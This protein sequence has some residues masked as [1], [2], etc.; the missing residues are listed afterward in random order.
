[1]RRWLA[2]HRD[3]GLQLFALY[4]LL[5]VPFL[6]TLWAFDGLIGVRIRRDVQASNLALAQSISQEV[7]LA[8]AKALN[9]VA[10]LSTYEGVIKADE[11]A[12]GEIFNLV[13][14]TS[15]EVNLVYRLGPN[16]IMLYHAPT[17]PGSTVGVDFSFRD[18][19]QA[20]L[21]TD[22][23][24]VSLGRIS[25]TTNQAVATAVM[26]LWSDDGVFLGLIGA[27][28][29]LESLSQ[30]LTAVISEHQI[31]EGLQ[32]VILDAAN[33][34]IAYP[35]P[36]YLLH[37][38]QDIIPEGYLV[39]FNGEND[40][41]IA[42]APQ[43]EERLYTR[44]SIPNIHWQ[45][46]VSRPTA[47]AFATQIILRRIVLVAA[48]TFILI[49]LFFWGMLTVRVIHPIERL[50]PI[51]EAI[52]LNQPISPPDQRY[53]FTESKRSDQIGNLIQS[54]I[55]MRD[56]IQERIR[57]QATLLETST[58]VV[59]SLDTETVLNR[60]LEQMGRL[61]QIKMYAVIALDETNGSFRIRASRGLSK[62]FT[63]Q[64]SIQ[65]SEPDSVT[66][67]ALHVHEPVQV[68]DTETDPSY[69]I[70]KHRA[71]LEG[72]RAVLAVPLNTKHAPPTALLVFH[73]TPHIFT[74]NEIQLLTSFAN[75]A[76]MAIEHAVL[77]ERSDMRLR[78]QT[79]RLEA[80]VESL[81][82]G[83]ILTDLH[84]KIIYANKRI[85][86][87][88]ELDIKNLS[89]MHADQI[90]ARIIEKASDPPARH[91]P[92]HNLLK[93][94]GESKMEI[95]CTLQNQTVHLRLE[96]FSV[97][98]EQG[99]PIGHGI[100]FHDITADWE[101][102][103]V[104]SSLVSTVSHELRTPLAAI[105]GY[106]STMLADD[107][108]WDHA[109][110]REFLT[111]ISDETDRLTSLVNNL[112]DL[113]RI[114]AGSL[115]LSMEKCNTETVIRNA[116]K[117]ARLSPQNIFK[118]SIAP[119]AA[120]LYADRLRLESILRNLIENSVKYAGET[121]TI[122][123][124]V[125]RSAGEIVFRVKDNGPGIPLKEKEHVFE[126]FY[127]VDEGLTRP[128]SGA[129]LGLTICQGLVT[130]HGGR[131]WVEPQLE[132]ACIAFTIPVKSRTATS[133]V[134]R[135]RSN[136]HQRSGR[137]RRKAPA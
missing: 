125:E 75:H 5:I 8:I 26:P 91:K 104:R 90:L 103:R 96:V 101:L 46:I 33:Q 108:E 95:T 41:Q 102:D 12:M 50:V 39:N 126:R 18:Y 52:G 16:G 56:S 79:Q 124:E 109:S 64:L 48:G 14:A 85:G 54:I 20:A 24:L 57:E 135:T 70:R 3:L 94:G 77:F 134:R 36:Q 115:K 59:S 27:N 58:A 117:E 131:I 1:M 81:H 67:R 112:L 2:F 111:I 93:T 17:G 4:L 83:L 9:T 118:V 51:S 130:A 88:A 73:P 98:D 69:A 82:D 120:A 45:V 89:G 30:T 87:L 84:G 86:E 19:F 6:V 42:S 92:P 121:A 122:K 62:Q 119:K 116:A 61:L 32:V 15:P 128:T 105:K 114:E 31:E 60:I 132:G 80:L 107:V 68:S 53:L 63:E 78:E 136:E 127:R 49:G 21:L 72:F 28:I 13:L 47:A 10:G 97:N 129:G 106:V 43:G 25:P 110:Q 22:Q 37:P 40:S 38:A 35:D 55:G 11:A 66:M 74:A 44:A 71:R 99:T 29:R 113:S 100:L 65:P 23:P 7:N 133:A 76:A 137:G 123:V 34:I